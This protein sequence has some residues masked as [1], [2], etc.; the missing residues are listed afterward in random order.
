VRVGG[1]AVSGCRVRRHA[2]SSYAVVLKEAPRA[3]WRACGGRGA[4]VI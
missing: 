1:R 2:A 4:E 3:Q